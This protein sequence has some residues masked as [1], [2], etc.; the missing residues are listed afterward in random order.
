MRE[1]IRNTRELALI[2]RHWTAR[3]SLALAAIATLAL[4]SG[5]A[6][7]V[8]S[9]LDALALR[10]LPWPNADRLVVVHATLPAERVNPGKTD[11]WDRAPITWA[12]WEGLQG[13]PAFEEVGVWMSSRQIL[14]VP[15]T[16]GYVRSE[17]VE[18]VHAST[19]YL[20]LLGAR[21]L[22]G[23]LF[24]P[25][26][27]TDTGTESVILSHSTWRRL[28][29]GKE[30]VIGQAVTIRPA[31]QFAGARKTIV[32]VL[33]SRLT[34]PGGEPA[35][36]LPIGLQSWNAKYSENGFLRALARLA[37]GVT[38]ESAEAMAQA[39]VRGPE[40]PGRR[41]A[42]VV[43]LR[44][45][46][47]GRF[48]PS[49]WLLFAGSSIVLVISLTVVGGLLLNDVVSRRR[50]LAIR[51]ALG[52][53]KRQ[54]AT[55]IVVEQATLGIVAA[56]LGAAMAWPISSGLSRIA[57]LESGGLLNST[58]DARAAGAAAVI[59]TTSLVV[60]GLV[61][62]RSLSHAQLQAGGA[63]ATQ[64]TRRRGVAEKT[65]LGAVL[66]LTVALTSGAGLFADAVLRMRARPM[67][68]NPDRLAIIGLEPA[69]VRS[70]TAR[71][72]ATLGGASPGGGLPAVRSPFAQRRGEA[73][74]ARAA[75]TSWVHTASL[76]DHLAAVPEVRAVAGVLAAPFG[77]GW[78]DAP[79]RI[80]G[81]PA[82]DTYVVQVQAVT[83]AYFE[84]MGIPV[85]A[86]R[87]LDADDRLT[88][89]VVVSEAFRRR[90]LEGDGLGAEFT[91]SGFRYVVVGVVGNVSHLGFADDS[92][93]CY[94]RLDTTVAHVNHLV[95]RTA[96]DPAA[97]L[98]A[99]RE[100]IRAYNP[101]LLITSSHTMR[102]LL[103][104]ALAEEALRAR[105]S[106]AFCALSL[107]LAST[108]LVSLLRRQVVER[109]REIGIRLALGARPRH[110]YGV[111]M[112]QAGHSVFIGIVGGL[113]ASL[114]VVRGA[115]AVAEGLSAATSV[116][117][118]GATS[119]MLLVALLAAI[120][121]ARRASRID[122]ARA[123]H[124]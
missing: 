44:D 80:V 119:L 42:R 122:P 62:A 87:A 116:V 67:G 40:P 29:G 91:R 2:I 19:A 55:H 118:A 3:P 39:S 86:G 9:V 50:E 112:R 25:E 37:P 16:G 84:V 28:F 85:L 89:R 14:D 26:E 78:Q 123:L 83:P 65:A 66:A 48:V 45:E 70:T 34:F 61:A 35:L 98:P 108:G 63:V 21:P 22:M 5:G 81:D 31:L 106:V 94:Y 4:G 104:L 15:D 110:V 109:Y 103:T 73:L 100:A 30:D 56:A 36:L 72:P 88:G 47:V 33:P 113:L 75:L 60:L 20:S 23:R 124:D 117:L 79:V 8:F 77:G 114:V 115:V 111:I 96:G 54:L 107:L 120:G 17:A 11:T 71:P 69:Q 105:T 95:V 27:D 52:A 38:P 49:F 58:L 59:V 10:A 43:A 57:G 6:V 13:S 18:V 97:A 101:H 99:V 53:S 93:P 92:L 76:L 32:G 121:P 74:E 12:A 64:A 90:F 24:T 68:F 1:W 41:T 7:G 51:L 102:N 46:L 82:D